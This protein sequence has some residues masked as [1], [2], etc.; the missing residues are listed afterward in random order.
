MDTLSKEK[1]DCLE[2]LRKV[3][4]ELQLIEQFEGRAIQEVDDLRKDK[5]TKA[6]SIQFI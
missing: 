3:Q 4:K 1:K 6:E 5:E 2:R